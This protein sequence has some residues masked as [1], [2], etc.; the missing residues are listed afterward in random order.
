MTYYCEK[1]CTSLLKSVLVSKVRIHLR[2]VESVEGEVLFLNICFDSDK[3][4]VFNCIAIIKHTHM[5]RLF[6][7]D[8]CVL[9]LR[10]HFHPLCG[11]IKDLS[12][13]QAPGLNLNPSL[14]LI[15]ITAK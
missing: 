15:V 11:Q 3:L 6:L 1:V 12:P 5:L 8:K 4:L 2:L 7:K 10:F 14:P 9:K 13:R